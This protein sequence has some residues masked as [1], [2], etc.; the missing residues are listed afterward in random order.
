MNYDKHYVV[1][2]PTLMDD[3]PVIN[4]FTKFWPL[5]GFT[6]VVQKFG[7]KE[8]KDEKGVR[9]N[10]DKIIAEI[11]SL[12]RKGKVSLIGCSAGGSAAINVFSQRAESINKVI[13][14]CGALS[15][16]SILSKF[17]TPAYISS[18]KCCEK[19]ISEMDIEK[20]QRIM[21]IRPRFGDEFIKKELVGIKGAKNV[22]IPTI[23]HMFTILMSLIFFS[24][25]IFNFLREN[26]K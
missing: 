19:S 7:W 16:D 17:D 8:I 21:T 10:I 25:L 22:T 2:L 20:R 5:F 15:S 14:I 24:K 18:L 3:A 1:I 11:D 26:N 4:L 12:S 23:E 9:Q 6:P 13:N